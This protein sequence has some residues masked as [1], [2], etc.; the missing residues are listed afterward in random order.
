[1]TESA[2]A[3]IFDMDGLLIDSEPLWV[4]AEI[5]IFAT[6]GVRLTHED[7]AKTKGLRVDDVVSH[8]HSRGGFA[9]A[10]P[11]DVEGRL[12][13][14]VVELV[15]AE[16]T[17]LPGIADA[18]DAARSVPRRPVALASSSP[19]VIIEA[20]L[21]RLGLR[22]AFDAVISAEREPFG[23]P[24]PAVFL[25]TA[26]QLGA[27]AVRCV[28]LEDSMTGV[29]A[30]KAARMACVAVPPEPGADPRFAVADAVL[31][32]LAEVTPA[33]LDRVIPR[34]G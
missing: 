17:A 14:R 34:H 28:V 7:C 18:L 16:G 2:G 11:A 31:R 8:W 27:P 29:I 19:M 22:G 32:S 30:A 12:I 33:L 25:R 20:A 5:E 9:G 4:R 23:K 13:A 24:H 15:R 3:I 1:M 6:V 26:E 10:S 21:E